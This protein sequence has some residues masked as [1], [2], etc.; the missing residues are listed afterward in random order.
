MVA[1]LTIATDLIWSFTECTPG[2]LGEHCTCCNFQLSSCTPFPVFCRGTENVSGIHQTHPSDDVTEKE[3]DE[4]EGVGG[5]GAI[6]GE[7][8]REE[9]QEQAEGEMTSHPLSHYLRCTS[10]PPSH[11][12]PNQRG[13]LPSI[14]SE[15]AGV[16]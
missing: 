1:V 6:N 15:G 16:S 5:L 4:M 13:V 10:L 3:E 8:K 11:L 12:F 7:Q 9:G 14:L 2:N